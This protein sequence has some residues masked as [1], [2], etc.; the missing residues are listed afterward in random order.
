GREP[1]RPVVA[2]VLN[3][4]ADRCLCRRRRQG[5]EPAQRDRATG[6]DGDHSTLGLPHTNSILV[7]KC[8]GA[9][10]LVRPGNGPGRTSRH[11]PVGVRVTCCWCRCTAPESAAG[12]AVRALAPV[13]L[14]PSPALPPCPGWA[15]RARGPGRGLA[16]IGASPSRG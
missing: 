14:D 8:H 2:L 13:A 1:A 12:P 11:D 15:P 5:H 6:D 3:V 9:D 10:D 16:I 7:S 4:A